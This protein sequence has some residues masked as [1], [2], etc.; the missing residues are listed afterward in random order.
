MDSEMKIFQVSA[1]ERIEYASLLK[2]ISNQSQRLHSTCTIKSRNLSTRLDF[3]FF[4]AIMAPPRPPRLMM[5]RSDEVSAPE[6]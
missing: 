2:G 6:A 1:A 3:P 4:R 5:S